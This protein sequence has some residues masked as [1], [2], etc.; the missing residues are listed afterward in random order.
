MKRSKEHLFEK[1]E[2][3]NIRKIRRTA[4]KWT[5]KLVKR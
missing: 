4:E 5:Q 3:E 1:I 2:E